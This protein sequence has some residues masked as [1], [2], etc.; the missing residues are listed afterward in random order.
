MHVGRGPASRMFRKNEIT[1]ILTPP[2]GR[3]RDK[4][5]ISFHNPYLQG[6]ELVAVEKI[7]NICITS[8]AI[9]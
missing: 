6:R 8:N 5:V 3:K 4:G 9:L 2:A 1:L 7:L